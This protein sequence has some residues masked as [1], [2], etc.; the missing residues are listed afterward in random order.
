[1]VIV[2]SKIHDSF[3]IEIK[4]SFVVN[5]DKKENDFSMGLWLFVPNS[6]DVNTYNYGK[7]Q[8][9]RDIKS[10]VRLMIPIFDIYD[11]CG[12]NSIP[13]ACLEKSLKKL[14]ENR[15]SKTLSEFEYNVKMFSSIIKS[16][17]RRRKEELASLELNLSTLQ[18]Y[19]DTIENNKFILD[20]YR[21]LYDTY[22]AD[23]SNKRRYQFF[24]LGDEYIGSLFEEFSFFLIKKIDSYNLDNDKFSS[25]RDSLV[26][27]I[28]NERLY[29]KSKGFVV[30]DKHNDEVN[31]YFIYRKNLL[32]K[33]IESHL[34]INLE[35]REDGVA[36]KQIY[37]SIAAGLAMIFATM[38]AFIT[39]IKY[40][41][42]S[43][44]LFVA[45]VISYML[46]D[47]IKELVRHFFV[48][49]LA[50][51]YFDNKAKV[52]VAGYDIG[53]H[54]EG[55]DFIDESKVPKEILSIRAQNSQFEA[56][57][58][59]LGEKV[60]LYREFVKLKND[61]TLD[62]Y[63]DYMFVGLN[64]IMRL[65]LNRF[66]SKMDNPYIPVNLLNSDG[67]V[68]TIN[69]LKIYNINFIIQLNQG[70][71]IQYKYYNCSLNRLGIQSLEELNTQF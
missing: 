35:K 42:L 58:N 12:E 31:Q 11:I 29:R 63:D 54:K 33:Y 43:A 23:A 68:E 59:I 60:M 28:R 17:I 53:E 26:A 57:N 50:D 39:Q 65:H 62:V 16:S 4:T 7:K 36:V 47:R 21:K 1:M 3:S 55:V 20:K 46:K 61:T 19:E 18:A 38:V 10:N 6:L 67:Q 13:Y 2:N 24:S 49:K 27:F 5:K 40:G 45:M 15:S 9:Y 66:I 56:E 41:S 64:N 22:L 70:S 52:V 44:A 25:I 69:A 14:T 51:R 37:Y 48:H 71:K 8:F 32:K 30:L 34:F